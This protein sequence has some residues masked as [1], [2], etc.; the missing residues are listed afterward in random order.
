VGGTILGLV[1]LGSIRKE[2]EQAMESNPVS[3][4][5]HSLFISPC[6]QVPDL[7]VEFLSPYPSVM[8]SNMK[9]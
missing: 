1:V 9:A 7:F 8:N 3:R 2:V 4:L 6:P 5:P